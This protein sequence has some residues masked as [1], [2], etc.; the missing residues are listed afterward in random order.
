MGCGASSTPAAVENRTA[1]TPTVSVPGELPMAGE[2]NLNY[3]SALST[4]TSS[5]HRYCHYTFMRETII[6]VP[7]QYKSS[8]HITT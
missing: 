4:N 2:F 5:G 7:V 3:H 1:A 8:F 6:C